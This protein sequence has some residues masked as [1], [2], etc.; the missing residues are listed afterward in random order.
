MV[1][2]KEKQNSLNWPSGDYAIPLS[3]YGCPASDNNNWSLGYI[4]ISFR[5]DVRLF[6]KQ[7]GEVGW[8]AAFLLLAG[9]YGHHSYQMNF[10]TSSNNGSKARWPIGTY[11]VFSTDN[12]N[13]G[14]PQG[15]FNILK[16]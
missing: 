7:L 4:N 2:F 16:G 12:A 8:N 9:P 3:V 15:G 11:S 10:C 1:L 6:E 5:N 13:R 14:C